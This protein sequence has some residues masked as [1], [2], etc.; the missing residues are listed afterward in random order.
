M[1]L[2]FGQRS[3]ASVTVV[4]LFV[5]FLPHCLTKRSFSIQ[6]KPCS[7]VFATILFESEH[8]FARNTVGLSKFYIAPTLGTVA[9]MF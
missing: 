8:G 9:V 4:I 6:R 1:V 5:K 2:T 7:T 3:E